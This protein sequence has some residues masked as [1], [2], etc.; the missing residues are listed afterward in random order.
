MGANRGRKRSLLSGLGLLVLGSLP[1]LPSCGDSDPAGLDTSTLEMLVVGGDGQA[2]E[3]GATLPSPFQVRVQSK[4]NGSPTEGAKVRWE[5]LEGSG[6]A[7]DSV[8]SV[9]DSLGLATARLT[10]GSDLGTYRIQVSLRGP[11]A[12]SVQFMASSIL[13][14]Q[15][16][17]VPMDPVPAGSVISIQGSHFS[18]QPSENVVTFSRLRGEGDSVGP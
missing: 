10:L 14:P 12:P 15:L 2:A 18:L 13:P 9:T 11:E 17:G 5:I 4:G 16:T 3:P 8:A 6:A 7:L 1:V